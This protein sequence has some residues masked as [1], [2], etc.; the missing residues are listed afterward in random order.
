MDAPAG[1]TRRGQATAAPGTETNAAEKAASPGPRNG[2]QGTRWNC[3]RRGGLFGDPRGATGTNA[4]W[5]GGET[6]TGA[7]DLEVVACRRHRRLGRRM[8]HLAQPTDRLERAYAASFGSPADSRSPVALRAPAR[9][10]VAVSWRGRFP[11]EVTDRRAPAAGL[12]TCP[13]SS[14]TLHAA[15]SR[16]PLPCSRGC[17]LVSRVSRLFKNLRGS[18]CALSPTFSTEITT[19]FWRRCRTTPTSRAAGSYAPCHEARGAGR[20]RGGAG[21]GRGGL[22]VVVAARFVASRAHAGRVDA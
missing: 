7:A 1:A 17:R 12:R 4:C 10:R 22:R 20:D 2:G 21:G 8:T 19:F 6:L 5:A 9:A 15:P 14:R 18:A 11:A 16:L 3:G 13:G